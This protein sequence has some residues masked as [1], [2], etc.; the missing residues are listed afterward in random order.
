MKHMERLRE[1]YAYDPASGAFT[2]VK[3]R[4]GTQKNIGERVDCLV[5]NHNGRRYRRVYALGKWYLAHRLAWYFYYGVTPP[6]FIDHRNG[7]GEDNR[8]ENLRAATKTENNRN[9][10]RGRSNTSGYKGVSWH[11]QRCKWR[12]S[13]VV[14]RQQKHIGLFDTAEEAH[15]AYAQHA[16]REHGEFACLGNH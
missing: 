9:A 4:S 10:I 3:K 15:A 2:C 7:D 16:L 8:I 11:K 5:V 6:Q 12:A 1:F 14:D 13:I